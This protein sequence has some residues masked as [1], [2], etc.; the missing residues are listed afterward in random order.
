M[1]SEAGAMVDQAVLHLV[2]GR[3]PAD[4]VRTLAD[5][6]GEDAAAS[7]VE[8]A[9]E[10]IAQ[11]ADT[12]RVEEIGRAKIRL[13]DLYR[14]ATESAMPAVALSAV[15]ERNKLLDLYP[16]DSD[17]DDGAGHQS[18]LAGVLEAIGDHLRPLGLLPAEQPLVEHARAAAEWVMR[19]RADASGN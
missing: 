1:A 15:R 13:D 16:R 2:G 3:A 11:A 4:L 19:N 6:I 18:E 8:L 5:R 12:V 17:A 14:L 9:R 7:L 10:R